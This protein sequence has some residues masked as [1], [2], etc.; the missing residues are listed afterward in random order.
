MKYI[1]AIAFTMLAVLAADLIYL[2]H[3][4]AWY[5][6]STII[7]HIEIAILYIF[8]GTGVWLAIYEVIK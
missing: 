2:H 6:P 8:V 3:V 7:W 1:K 5:D 4:G